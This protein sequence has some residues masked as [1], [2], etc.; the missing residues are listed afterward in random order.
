MVLCLVGFA[1]EE[2]H[3]FSKPS[4]PPLGEFRHCRTS[5]FGFC[6][7]WDLQKNTGLRNCLGN[8]RLQANRCNTAFQIPRGR[9]VQNYQLPTFA[10]LKQVLLC[11]PCYRQQPNVGPEIPS[12]AEQIGGVGASARKSK[13][14][15]WLEKMFFA[16]TGLGSNPCC[17]VL[18]WLICPEQTLLQQAASQSLQQRMSDSVRHWSLKFPESSAKAAFSDQQEN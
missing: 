11:G 16:S 15:N 8:C 7:T 2:L 12:N 18:P 6:W 3:S 1:S 5:I 17:V 13:I 14:A 10:V 4:P 9:G